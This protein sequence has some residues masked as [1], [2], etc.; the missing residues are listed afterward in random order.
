MSQA[1]SNIKALISTLQTDFVKNFT[2][3]EKLHRL[4]PKIKLQD[5]D[6]ITELKKLSQILKAH[7]TKIGI[8]LHPDKFYNNLDAVFKEIQSLAN[9]IFF[10]ISLI[11]LFYQEEYP[12]YFTSLLDANVLSLLNGVGGLCEELNQ[13][14]SAPSDQQNASASDDS[15]SA[16]LVPIGKIWAVCDQTLE[17]SDMGELGLLNKKIKVSS[18]LVSD[19]LTELE[20]WLAEPRIETDDPFGLESD[21]EE[22]EQGEEEDTETQEVPPKMIQFVQEWQTKLKMIRLLLQSFSK[23]IASNDYKNKKPT[24]LQLDRLNALHGRIVAEVD[25][26]I[27]STFMGGQD[28]DSQDEEI[29]QLAGQVDLAVREMVKIIKDVNKNDEKKGKWIQVWDNKYFS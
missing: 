15:A 28:F 16:R 3:S 18:K 22:E 23:S 24:S 8:I 19:T 7:A 27:S 17:L 26:L 12:E 2:S 13:L 10:L 14:L 21:S 4:K 20:E 6:P 5:S 25:E 29:T 9:S 1:E 11:P